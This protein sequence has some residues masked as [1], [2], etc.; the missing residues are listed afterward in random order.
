MN[1]R[2][3]VISTVHSKPRVLQQQSSSLIG[4]DNLLSQNLCITD[5]KQE[6]SMFCFTEKTIIFVFDDIQALI[7]DKLGG[8]EKKEMPDWFCQFNDEDFENDA[9]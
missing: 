6:K 4:Y 8:N 1:F 5:R 9:M 7:E 3:I 2:I